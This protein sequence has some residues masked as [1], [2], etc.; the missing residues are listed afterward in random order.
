MKSVTVTIDGK[1][2]EGTYYVQNSIAFVQSPFGAKA[3]QIG[4]FSPEMIARMVLSELVR[5]GSST[6]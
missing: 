1:T 3:N 2:F 6:D 4:G 5:A